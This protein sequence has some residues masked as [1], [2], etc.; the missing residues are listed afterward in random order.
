MTQKNT[1]N[2]ADREEIWHP[3]FNTIPALRFQ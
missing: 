3:A 2:T 1:L